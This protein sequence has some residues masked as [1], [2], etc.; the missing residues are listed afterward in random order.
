MTKHNGRR[1]KLGPTVELCCGEAC[2]RGMMTAA[3]AE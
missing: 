2:R 1:H 3:A